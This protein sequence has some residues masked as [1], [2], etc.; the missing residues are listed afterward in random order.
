MKRIVLGKTGLEVNRLGFGGI[1]IQRVDEETAVEVVLNAV[2]KGVD[3][4]DTARGYT[5]SERCIGMALKQT[6][7][8][9]LICSKSHNRTADG[10]RADLEESLKQLQK[11][12]IDI[13]MCHFIKDEEEYRK[14]ISPGGAFEGL[15]KA[16]EEGLIGHIGMSSHSLDLIEK[17]LDDDLFEA[18]MLCYSFLEPAAEEKVIPKA[19]EKGVG[20]IA[21]K[22]F[23]GGVI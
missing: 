12:Y 5:T 3:F 4:I 7:R 19:I 17:I 1:P 15:A 8:R 16:K 6:D 10:I 20:I 22:P 2:E 9:V 21:M 18:I 23:S 14:V 13:H 11:D